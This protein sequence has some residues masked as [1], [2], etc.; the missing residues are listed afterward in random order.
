MDLYCDLTCLPIAVGNLYCPGPGR[1]SFAPHAPSFGRAR[2]RVNTAEGTLLSLDDMGF[3]SPAALRPSV[4][5]L[6]SIPRMH[7]TVQRVR[8]G[9]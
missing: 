8:N 5:G 7:Q 2:A 1:F 4:R 3:T 6:M 9:Q